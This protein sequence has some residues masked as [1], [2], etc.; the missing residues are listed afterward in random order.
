MGRG[1]A[2]VKVL[3]VIDHLGSG[4]AQRQ[5]STLA[6]ELARRGHEVE[7][8]VY[9]PQFDFFREGLDAVGIAVHSVFK[10]RVGFWG[11]LAALRRT[12]R[13]RRPD[14]VVA[15]LGSPAVYSVLATMLSAHAPRLVVS[16][17]SSHHAESPAV[18]RRVRGLL[19]R[20][21][22]ARTDAVVCNSASQAQWLRAR[23]FWLRSKVHCIFNGLPEEAFVGPA[24]PPA[25]SHL[26]LLAIG[27]VGPEK[28]PLGLVRAMQ[29]LR[30][31][32]EPLP[33]VSW[34][35][36]D[37]ESGPGRAYRARIDA[38]LQAEP[39]IAGHL[40][41]LGRQR[42]IG[43]LLLSH[44]ALIHPALYEGFPN[45]VCEAFAAARPVLLSNVCDHPQL[46][47]QGE[48]GLLFD[49]CDGASIAQAIL[50]LARLSPAARQAMGE[51]GA[52]FAREHL[53]ASR[54]AQRF[55][56][57]LRGD[58]LGASFP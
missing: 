36:P 24:P 37:D 22:F 15:F 50:A 4:G 42:D 12:L 52:H 56:A 41:W 21:L 33:Q 28:N 26:R 30:A 48:R 16:E 17:R 32:G 43:T 49:P 6:C 57:L 47:G 18:A 5:L 51:C 46:A 29:W 10:Q 31:R 23:H 55:E 19:Q 44:D 38:E 14:A 9:Y 35:G 20:V 8:F 54:M 13:E 58:P 11:V 53:A 45:A 34:V 7:V 25:G 2:H 27:R 1:E 3:C 39:E 40:Q